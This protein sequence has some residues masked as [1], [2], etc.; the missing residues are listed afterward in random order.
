M[1]ELNVSLV[2]EIYKSRFE[3]HFKYHP[4]KDQIVAKLVEGANSTEQIDIW[5]AE[6]DYYTAEHFRKVT[7]KMPVN[8]DGTVTFK[9]HKRD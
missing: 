3:E 8:E 9:I 6:A 2:G 4:N 5:F 1:G 7:N